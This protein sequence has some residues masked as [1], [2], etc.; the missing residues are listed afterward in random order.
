MKGLLRKDFY[1]LTSDCRLFLVVIVLFLLVGMLTET[2]TVFLF[3]PCMFAG[4]LPVTLQAYDERSGWCRYSG[5]M[6]YTRAQMVSV[7]YLFALLLGCAVVMLAGVAYL[8]PIGTADPHGLISLLA[9]A[10]SLT[11]IFPALLMPF[12]FRFG[13]EKGR[14]A[15]LI[16]VGGLC[17]GGYLLFH[18]GH[19]PPQLGGSGWQGMLIGAA[20][21]LFAGSWLL[22]VAIYQSRASL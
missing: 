17:A 11:L 5:T 2:D 22:S 9:V 20:V 18:G 4:L 13:S 19:M 16:L 3:I 10:G 12:V 8:L 15:Y 1:M 14:I 7:K 6:P 21:L